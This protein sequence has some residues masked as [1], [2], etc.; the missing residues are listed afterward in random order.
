MR[1][2]LQYYLYELSKDLGFLLA[3]SPAT[4]PSTQKWEDGATASELEMI[5]SKKAAIRQQTGNAMQAMQQAMDVQA[6]LQ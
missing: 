5:E 1:E 2:R 3:D 6:K 4:L